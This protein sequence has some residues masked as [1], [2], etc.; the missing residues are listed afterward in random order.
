MWHSATISRSLMALIILKVAKTFIGRMLFFG[1]SFDPSSIPGRY[2]ALTNRAFRPHRLKKRIASAFFRLHRAR[3]S[4]LHCGWGEPV[5]FTPADRNA[6]VL[7]DFW[8]ISNFIGR[9]LGR[10]GQPI[11]ARKVFCFSLPSLPSLPSLLSCPS[12]PFLFVPA[13]PCRYPRRRS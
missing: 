10:G 3:T 6:V 4:E 13:C 8:R 7:S 11:P 12:F 2:E 5:G 9:I 1:E